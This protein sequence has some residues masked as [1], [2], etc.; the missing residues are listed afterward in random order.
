M[1]DAYNMV[2]FQCHLKYGE[3]KRVLQL[4][5]GLENAEFIRFGQMHRNTFI[6]SPRVLDVTLQ[7]KKHPGVLFAGQISGS[8]GYTETATG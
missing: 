8:E 7:M 1:A 3:Q 5:P 6:C 4:I 2:G